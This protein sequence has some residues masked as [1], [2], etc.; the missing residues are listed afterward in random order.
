MDILSHPIFSVNILF[1]FGMEFQN[2]SEKIKKPRH[3]FVSGF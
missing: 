2:F 3:D 1:T